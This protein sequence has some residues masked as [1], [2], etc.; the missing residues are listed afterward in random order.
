MQLH[1]THNFKKNLDGIEEFLVEIDACH[2][3]TSLLDDLFDQVFPM[4]KQFPESGI[5]FFRHPPKSQAV[6]A[7]LVKLRGSKLQLRE[8]IHGDYLLLY[9]LCGQNLYLLSIKHHRQL[10]F[11]LS[12]YLTV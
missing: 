9:G 8:L 6:L 2:S 1:V 7:R 4:L 12:D 10:S 5:D 11:D 3:F